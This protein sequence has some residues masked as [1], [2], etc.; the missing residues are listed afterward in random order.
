MAKRSGVIE[1]TASWRE[2]IWRRKSAGSES[3]NNIETIEE[4]RRESGEENQSNGGGIE[5]AKWR[6][7]K[8]ASTKRK[9]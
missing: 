3:R 6:Q 7:A 1:M 5:A 8:A 2:E 4:T 9:R